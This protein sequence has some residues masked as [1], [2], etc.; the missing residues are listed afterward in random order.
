[1]P[2]SDTRI[3]DG[4]LAVAQ[5][6]EG[7][8][9]RLALQGELDLSNAP[10]LEASLTNAIDSG[11]KVVIDLD[12]LEFLDSTGIALLVGVL[13]RHDA[14]RFSFLPSRSSGVCRLL[15][16]TGLDKR[17]VRSTTAAP[18]AALPAAS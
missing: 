5:S 1:V 11:K 9:V 17:M 16:L 8:Q 13:Q 2:L 12:Q 3:Q 6:D 7:A 15:N 10:T 14:E 4:L 18:G